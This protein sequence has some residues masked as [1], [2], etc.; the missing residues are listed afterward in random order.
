MKLIDYVLNRMTMY[1]LVV[2]ILSGYAVLGIFFALTGKLSFSATRMIVSLLLLLVS[3]YVTDRGL[4]RFFNIPTNMESWLITGLIL[5]LIIQPAHSLPTVLALILA[6]VVSSASKF[7]IT[8]R[9]K[10]FFNPAAF[11][12]AL[13]SLTAIQPTIWWIGSSIL[14]PYT[15]VFGLLIVRKVRRFALVLTFAATSIILQYFVFMAHH[16][17]LAQGMKAALIASPLIFL[18]TIMLTEPAT[19]PARRG[20]QMIFGIIVAVFYVMGWKI[21]RLYI[22]PEVALLLGNIYAF[23]V[24][25]K[26]RL[27]LRLQEVQRVSDQI[28]HY[29]FQPDQHF[30]FQP[31]QYLEWTLADVPYDSRGNRRTFTIASS[32]TEATVQLGLKYYEPA[33]TYKATFAQLQPGDTIFASELAGNFT[34]EPHTGKLAFIAGGIGITPFRSMIKYLTDQNEQRD[35]VLIYVI[36]QPDE[37]AYRAEILAA[38]QIGVRCIPVITEPGHEKLT[39]AVNAKLDKDLLASLIPDRAERTFY[40]SGPDGMVNATTHYLH[41]LHVPRTHIKTDHFS[42]Y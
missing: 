3:A 11:A 6:G 36:N 18:S 30:N 25:P 24:S 42:G 29:I 2:Y 32:P 16:Q 40:I 9:N 12:A 37:L 4:A 33:S 13:L 19:M 22:Y 8:W 34:L 28:Y 23:A 21:G 27:R 5:F 15:L 20:Q 39:G 41:Q 14:W 35:I 31:G 26:L 38:R 10:H 1:R 17:P 7:I